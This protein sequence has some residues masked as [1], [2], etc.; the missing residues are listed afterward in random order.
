MV[1][2]SKHIGTCVTDIY[3][4]P[5]VEWNITATA[6]YTSTFVSFLPKDP[7][8]T[9]VP[10]LTTGT[11]VVTTATTV[12]I[13]VRTVV[14][15]SI[16]PELVTTAFPQL[17]LR[18]KNKGPLT[19]KFSPP[20][21]CTQLTLAPNNSYQTFFQNETIW[22]NFPQ[23]PATNWASCYPP[24]FTDAGSGWWYSPGIC[25]SS[26]VATP[27]GAASESTAVC[28]PNGYNFRAGVAG[29]LDRYCTSTIGQQTHAITY[30]GSTTDLIPIQTGKSAYALPIHIRWQ[31]TDAV[32]PTFS[33]SLG[34]SNAKYIII[35]VTIAVGIPLMVLL[36]L[37]FRASRKKKR[38]EERGK[39]EKDAAADMGAIETWPK[40]ELD[41]DAR[42]IFSELP[43]HD[44]HELSEALEMHEMDPDTISVVPQELEGSG[45]SELSST[46]T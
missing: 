36:A 37:F 25:P 44:V 27:V 30:W 7:T 29:N 3:K 20:K 33:T 43:S 23:Y 42:K 46:T 1:K 4:M 31:D 11:T 24:G 2:P 9:G 6:G 16:S 12:V 32:K 45:V 34:E 39:A 13:T 40:A 10:S 22:R 38:R 18:L 19:T 14:T 8:R 21:D 17:P 41:E 15:T 35:T 5:P 26:W 28:C